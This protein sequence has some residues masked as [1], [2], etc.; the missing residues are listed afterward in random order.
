M[1]GTPSAH[2]IDQ[3]R[4]FVV[5]RVYREIYRGGVTPEL[6]LVD[7]PVSSAA[8][9]RFGRASRIYVSRDA[10]DASL[11]ALRG[12]LA[13]EY[14]H[15]LDPDHWRDT[16]MQVVGWVALKL[17]AIVAL[18]VY[19]LVADADASSWLVVGSWLAGWPTLLASFCWAAHF[20]YK[21]E[22][23]ADRTA[24]GLLGDVAP[25]IAMVERLAAVRAGHS[26]LQHLLARRSHPDPAR[27]RRALTALQGAVA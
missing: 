11:D 22:L 9:G 24:A 4:L 18:M 17:A 1:L 16:A 8:R 20:S 23:R 3:E 14:A 25:V 6:H 5:Q 15:L 21:I 13:H 26:R 2:E 19:P 12:D 27:R 10:V 7:G